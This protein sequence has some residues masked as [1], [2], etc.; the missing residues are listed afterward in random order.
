M[1][2]THR[3]QSGWRLGCGDNPQSTVRMA[4]W[5]WRLPMEYSQDGDLDV[6]I[7]HGVQ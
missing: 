7:A 1:E 6:E 5:M 3:V 4:T 2:I